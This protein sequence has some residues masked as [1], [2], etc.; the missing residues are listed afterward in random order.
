[1][2][3]IFDLD[4]TLVDTSGSI[5]E[6]HL[7]AALQAMIQQGLQVDS[8]EK[9]FQ[10]LKAVDAQ[11]PNGKETFRLFLTQSKQDNPQLFEIAN[12][13]YYAP[14]PEDNTLPIPTLPDAHHILT[15]LAK[16]HRLCI[17]S[18]GNS[19]LQYHKLQQAQIPLSLFAKII[20]LNEYNKKEAYSH[21]LKECTI[22]PS[23]TIV[24]G[25]KVSTD[26]LPAKELGCHT[27]HISWGRGKVTLPKPLEVDYSISFLKELLPLIAEIQCKL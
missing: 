15:S 22:S 12:T 21:L 26:L 16:S 9:A 18:T 19:K 13:I 24:C 14:L 25:D 17:I 6:Y 27:I 5:Q 7:R 11:S 10:Q 1:M 2:L 3:I 20:I 23:Q 8:E 4:D